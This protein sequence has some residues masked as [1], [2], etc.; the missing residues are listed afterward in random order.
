[1]STTSTLQQVTI[2]PPSAVHHAFMKKAIETGNQSFYPSAHRMVASSDNNNNDNINTL[3]PLKK[4]RLELALTHDQPMETFAV[5]LQQQ[6]QSQLE[7]RC[8]ICKD[9]VGNILFYRPALA[10][11]TLFQVPKPTFASQQD[12]APS[13]RRSIDTTATY[14]QDQETQDSQQQGGHHDDISQRNNNSDDDDDDT[15]T[16]SNNIDGHTSRK[17]SQVTDDTYQDNNDTNS[18][19]DDRSL[20]RLVIPKQRQQYVT[21]Y[22]AKNNQPLW[23]LIEQDWHTMTLLSRQLPHQYILMTTSTFSFVWEGMGDNRFGSPQQQQPTPFLFPYQWHMKM[24]D[25]GKSMD[26]LCEQV[27]SDQTKKP[28]ALLTKQATQLILYGN[29]DPSIMANKGNSSNENQLDTTTSSI[30][31]NPFRSTQHS[32]NDDRQRKLDSLDAFLVLS[33]LLLYDLIHSQLYALGGGPEAMV[34]MI[35]RQQEALKEEM[36]IFH[37][38]YQYYTQ[39]QQQHLPTGAIMM[40]MDDDALRMNP[41]RYY[42]NHGLVAGGNDFDDDFDD[43]DDTSSLDRNGD[44]DHSFGVTNNRTRWSS[45]ASMKSLELDP[46]LWRCWW[47]YGCWWSLFPC[48]MPGGWCDRAWIKARGGARRKHHHHHHHHRSRVT[49]RMQGWQQQDE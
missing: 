28:V 19:L 45:S 33:S 20:Q 22:D 39:Q 38:Q 21:L 30:N 3:A 29:D 18:N 1:M 4:T 42:T 44:N 14:I 47:G 11:H 17:G 23:S 27:Q 37:R 10:L 12:H 24:A 49:R 40:V 36:G 6:Q 31:K 41:S 8:T 7:P 48:C 16:I 26:L 32:D 2:Q 46:G 9:N 5:D 25:D 35:E 13:R 43:D 34:M 15:N